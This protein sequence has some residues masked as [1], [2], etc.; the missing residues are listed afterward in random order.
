MPQS[1]ILL[2]HAK[3]NRRALGPFEVKLWSALSRS[4]LNG[5]KFRRQHVLE[6]A[7]VDFFC[8][9]KGLIVEVDGGTHDASRDAV[10]DARHAML[11]LKTLRFSNQEVG[12]NLGGVF[13][14][15]AAELE[16]TPDRWL[17]GPTLPHPTAAARLRPSPEGEGI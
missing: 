13:A 7:I 16:L 15:L 10:R 4:K 5:H 14:R 11:G 17:H 3:A 9:A 6:N 2:S 1:P 12:S 8:P